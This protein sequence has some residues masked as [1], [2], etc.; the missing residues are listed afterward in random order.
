M[1]LVCQARP[2]SSFSPLYLFYNF[3]SL[4]FSFFS[5]NISRCPT[6][7]FFYTFILR[8]IITWPDLVN[9][10]SLVS[11]G[12]FKS[13]NRTWI[14]GSFVLPRRVSLNFY[15]AFLFLLTYSLIVFASSIPLLTTNSY[16]CSA[17]FTSTSKS[18]HAFIF[19]SF[20][21]YF[22][23][24]MFFNPVVS[25]RVLLLLCCVFIPLYTPS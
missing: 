19:Q 15:F 23:F 9:C 8:T 4:F 21:L 11:F 14:A 20:L 5:S 2:L 24:F 7:L 13:N 18:D 16:I 17:S 3:A 6:P 10:L 12:R 1:S 22:H 25:F